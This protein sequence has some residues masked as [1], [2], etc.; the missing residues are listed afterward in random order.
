[1]STARSTPRTGR[2]VLKARLGLAWERLAAVWIP[3]VLTLGG[4]AVL[5]V[6]G[7]FE[8]LPRPVQAAA[9]AALLVA[10]LALAIL[11]LL[12]LRWPSEA[13]ARARLDADFDALDDHLAAGDAAL[14]ALHRRRAEEALAQ[15]RAGRMGAGIA[16][17]DPMALRY[18]LVVAA[19]LGLWAFGL[20]TGA[21]RLAQAVQPLGD[22]GGQAGAM[23]ADAGQATGRGVRVAMVKVGG[24]FEGAPRE[25][26]RMERVAV[27]SSAQTPGKPRILPAASRP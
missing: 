5:A 27:Q 24:L 4:L 23:L 2:A 9:V 20:Q 25:R 1:M 22:A 11:N 19:A 16:A 3:L 12:R 10:A 21:T 6:W 15:A 14:W 26:V 18:A 13:E 17:A 7:A 8:I